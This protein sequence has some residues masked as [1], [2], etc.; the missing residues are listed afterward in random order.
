MSLSKTIRKICI[1]LVALAL[2]MTIILA[3]IG[4]IMLQIEEIITLLENKK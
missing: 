1:V 3:P 4:I 2:M